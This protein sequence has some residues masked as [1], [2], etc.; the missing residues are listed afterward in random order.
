MMYT[1][2]ADEE[3]APASEQEG[4]LMYPPVC[5]VD[6]SQAIMFPTVW[7]RQPAIDRAMMTMVFDLWR[8]VR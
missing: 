6:L 1:M 4:D 5:C 7:M 8:R 2:E 3:A